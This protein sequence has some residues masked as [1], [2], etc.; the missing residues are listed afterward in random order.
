MKRLVTIMMQQGRWR[1]GPSRGRANEEAGLICM[2]DVDTTFAVLSLN[3]PPEDWDWRNPALKWHQL[4]DDGV[5]FGFLPGPRSDAPCVRLGNFCAWCVTI[6]KFMV[7][8]LMT[9]ELSRGASD[10]SATP[11][12]G[13]FTQTWEKTKKSYSSASFA[14]TPKCGPTCW[15][16]KIMSWIKRWVHLAP[17]LTCPHA[18]SIDINLNGLWVTKQLSKRAQFWPKASSGVHYRDIWYNEHG[19]LILKYNAY[20]PFKLHFKA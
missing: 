15:R 4:E 16:I 5:F 19:R 13:V 10:L 9:L 20:Y 1:G 14:V 12:V 17:L 11:A 2:E 8:I 18:W 7:W 3:P 6:R